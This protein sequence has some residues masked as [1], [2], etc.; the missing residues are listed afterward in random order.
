MRVGSLLLVLMCCTSAVAQIQNL[1]LSVAP[2]G[3]QLLAIQEQKKKALHYANAYAF[4]KWLRNLNLV[5]LFL[6]MLRPTFKVSNIEPN[7]P[8]LTLEPKAENVAIQL[9]PYAIALSAIGALVCEGIRAW[10]EKLFHLL[11]DK[12]IQDYA[13]G[14]VALNLEKTNGTVQLNV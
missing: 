2:A 5:F 4:W 7:K 13:K 6:G 14:K 9:P 8:A 11:P 1:E 12:I 3:P 10:Y